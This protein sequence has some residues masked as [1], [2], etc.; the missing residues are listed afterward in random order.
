MFKKSKIEQQLDLQSS[1]IQYIGKISYT[2][3][4][5]KTAWQNVFYEQFTSKIDESLFSSFYSSKNG[6]PNSPV[7]ELVAMMILK[8]GNGWSDLDLFENCRFNLLIRKALGK[9]NLDENIPS[10]STYYLF[11]KHIEDNKKETGIDLYNDCFN[12]ITKSQILEFNVSGKSVRMDSKLI[13][14]NIAK[15]SRYEI[16]HKS[17]CLFLKKNENSFFNLLTENEQKK[18]T[19]IKEEE[20]T[21]TIYRNTKTEILERLKELGTLI[22]KILSLTKDATN[23]EYLT[24]KRVFTEQYNVPEDEK[25]ELSLKEEISAQSVKSQNDKDCDNDKKNE[26]EVKEFSENISETSNK[27]E[28]RSNQEISAQSVQSPNDTDCHYRKKNEIEVKGF[29]HNLT[30][31]CN[32]DGLNLIIDIQTKPASAA[33]NHFVIKALDNASALLNDKIENVHTDGAYNDEENQKYTKEHEIN[34]YLTGIQGKE[35]RFELIPSKDNLEIFDKQTGEKIEVTKTKN[36]KYRITTENGYRYFGENEINKA[37]L[38][39]ELEQIPSEIKN[40][41]NNVEASIYQLA[42]H[43]RKDKTKYRGLSK[44]TSWAIL[45]CMWINFARIVKFTKQIDKKINNLVEIS[46]FNLIKKIFFS[47][48]FLTRLE[49]N[50]KL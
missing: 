13:G 24:L 34:F 26:I 37:L 32:E 22:F 49:L 48:L 7:R 38:R 15:F 43:L 27:V 50:E 25:L 18:L 33:D 39:K 6:C 2:K 23:T 8:E 3:F 14:S 17:F 11:R 5:D 1:V 42:F 30:E 45:R 36:E 4:V 40:V 12:K 44:N 19:E 9:I 20:S 21:K 35:S 46:I 41:R 10:E 47:I 29:S 16:I 31:T 28:L